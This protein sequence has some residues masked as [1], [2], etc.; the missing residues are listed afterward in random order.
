[1]WFI[2]RASILCG[3]IS[4]HQYK[5]SDSHLNEYDIKSLLC[6]DDLGPS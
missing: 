6:D 1:M 3:N 5:G 2:I 4:Y